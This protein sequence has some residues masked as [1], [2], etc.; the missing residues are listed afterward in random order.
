M[1]FFIYN[2]WSAVFILSQTIV[3]EVDKICRDYQW[4]STED[5]K[6]LALVSREKICFP[7]KFGG[8]NVKGSKL[9]N[10]AYVGKLLWQ[11]L[12]NKEALWVKWVHGLYISADCSW[13]WKK[14]NSL[15]EDMH[16]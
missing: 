12:N 2:F 13:F 5:R 10:V 7:K 16:G 11:L 1:L 6:K 3:K 14:V 8:L 9:W 15:K 4:G